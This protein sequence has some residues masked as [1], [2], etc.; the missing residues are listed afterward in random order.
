[1]NHSDQTWAGELAL[2]EGAT[3]E[4]FI[5]SKALWKTELAV[6]M[7]RLTHAATV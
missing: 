4:A 3:L 5:E 1:M 7:V 2:W 6:E